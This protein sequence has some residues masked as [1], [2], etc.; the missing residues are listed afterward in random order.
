MIRVRL[1]DGAVKEVTKGTTPMD[2]ASSI[3]EGLARN[4]LSASYNEQ[5][6][7]AVTPHLER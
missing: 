1:P 4:V 6:I 3:S 7:E 5:T 2:I